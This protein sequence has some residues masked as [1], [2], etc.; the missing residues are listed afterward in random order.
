M[1]NTTTLALPIVAFITGLG[2]SF[3]LPVMSL[4]LIE[5]LDVEPI[6][7]GLYTIAMT[8]SGIVFSQVLGHRTD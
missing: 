1:K 7:V 6:Y 3:V 4:F 5:S 2:M 8:I